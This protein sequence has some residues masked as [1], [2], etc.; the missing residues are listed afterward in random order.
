[1]ETQPLVSV[2][3]T[4]YNREKYIAAAIESVLASSYAN[5]ELIIVDDV[6]AD[7]SVSIAKSYADNDARIK[8]FVNERNLG[9]YPNRNKAA[10]FANGKYL[11]YVDADDFIYPWGL[12]LLVGMMEQYTEAGW[13]LCSIEPDDSRPF[14]FVLSPKQAYE[15]N[16]LGPGLFHKAPLSAIFRKD[17]F[18]AAGGFAPKRMTSDFEMWHRLS[19]S[20]N[21]L[22]MPH[23]IVWYRSHGDQEVKDVR[24]FVKEYEQIKINYLRNPNCPLDKH[25]IERI[26]SGTKR[27]LWKS[28]VKG[29]LLLNSGM[30]IDNFIRLKEY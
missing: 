22:V 16:F 5:F 20:Y 19:Q 23:G 18:D 30:V 24:D 28:I 10:S 3:M 17:V 14:P 15:Y 1:M 26:I 27:R 25:E 4:A 2:L 21:V 11:K 7:A 12:Q 9:D 6:S 8:V 29:M 13:G